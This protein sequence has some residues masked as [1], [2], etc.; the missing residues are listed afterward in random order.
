MF[1]HSRPGMSQFRGLIANKGSRRPGAP[2]NACPSRVKT[3]VDSTPRSAHGGPKETG[4]ID[5][6]EYQSAGLGGARAPRRRFS[7]QRENAKNSGPGG[8]HD[9]SRS[10]NRPAFLKPWA[11][12]TASAA[13][14][15]KCHLRDKRQDPYCQANAPVMNRGPTW[16]STVTRLRRSSLITLCGGHLRQEPS[17][18]C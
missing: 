15:I 17:E 1:H 8:R 4:Q 2:A 5:Y 14:T 16:R 3:A 18:P 7:H 12:K 6:H 9:G 10:G 11:R 13:C